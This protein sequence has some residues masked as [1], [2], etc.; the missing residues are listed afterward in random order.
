MDWNEKIEYR[1]VCRK[2]WN[3]VMAKG[4]NGQYYDECDE[5]L[6]DDY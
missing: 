5:C 2:C 6:D 1:L 4:Y 3:M